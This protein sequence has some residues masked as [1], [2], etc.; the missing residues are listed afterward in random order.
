MRGTLKR[1][2]GK[3]A[4]GDADRAA[5]LALDARVADRAKRYHLDE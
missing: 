3:T 2:L 1:R 5:A 4:E